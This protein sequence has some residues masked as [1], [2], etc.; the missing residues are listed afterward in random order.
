MNDEMGRA[1]KTHWE[2][3]NEYR[4]LVGKLEGKIPLRRTRRRWED[5]I[6]VHLRK[7]GWSGMY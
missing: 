3:R 6:K 7:I 1:C 4:Y 5:N 2:K